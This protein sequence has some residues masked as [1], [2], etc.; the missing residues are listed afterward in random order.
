MTEQITDENVER[1]R[2]VLQEISRREFFGSDFS[3]QER[4]QARRWL[5]DQCNPET[6]TAL[7]DTLEAV[8]VELAEVNQIFKVC[9]REE[10][11]NRDMRDQYR[12]EA[13]GLRGA[14]RYAVNQDGWLCSTDTGALV[15]MSRDN[16][17]VG[18]VALEKGWI[19][20]D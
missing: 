14:L 9:S 11:D 7:L 13:E 3:S 1:I 18:T 4:S 6:V 10:K 16:P 19:N 17:K 20:D 15:W 2:E 12:A 5:S 8:K